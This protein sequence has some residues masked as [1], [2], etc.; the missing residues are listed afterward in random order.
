M[1]QL[2]S[3]IAILTFFSTLFGCNDFL[4]RP[5]ASGLTEDVV[6]STMKDADKVL[7]SAY[8]FA[9]WGYPTYMGQ[10]GSW[11]YA[12]R[13]MNHNT[14]NMCD[15]AHTQLNDWSVQGLNYYLKGTLSSDL[16]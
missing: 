12:F 1:K 9:P 2:I 13:L 8:A 11:N 3:K 7:A 15:E 16:Q 4:E 10:D 6:F 14:T 5:D